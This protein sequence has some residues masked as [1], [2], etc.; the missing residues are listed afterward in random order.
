MAARASASTSS[1]SAVS[2]ARSSGWDAVRTRS[3]RG[4][5]SARGSC[6][7]RSRGAPAPRRSRC[8]RRSRRRRP[9][10]CEPRRCGPRATRS[11]RRARGPLR[12]GGP[13]RGGPPRARRACSRARAAG[14]PGPGG[15]RSSSSALARKRRV[16]RT[17]SR[18]SSVVAVD[19]GTTS[20]PRRMDTR[21]VRSRSTFTSRT[22]TSRSTSRIISVRFSAATSPR[23]TLSAYASIWACASAS[24]VRS[25][26]WEVSDSRISSRACPR[27]PRTTSTPTNATRPAAS[28]PMTMSFFIVGSPVGGRGDGKGPTALPGEP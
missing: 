16:R 28:R 14:A 21:A 19:V 6:C 20:S 18:S 13:A 2:A 15:V 5:C 1:N 12:R 8:S 7:G 4:A 11:R 24:C 23:I 17:A 9:R 10:G 26:I 3:T 25:G 27:A 22:R